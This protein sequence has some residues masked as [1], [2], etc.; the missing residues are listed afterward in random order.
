MYKETFMWNSIIV[1]TDG[2]DHFEVINFLHVYRIREGS[3]YVVH[4]GDYRNILLW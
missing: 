3:L 2:C 1:T 4:Y